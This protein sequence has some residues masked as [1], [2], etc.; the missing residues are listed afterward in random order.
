MTHLP[1]CIISVLV[2]FSSL[3]SRP[4][5][6]H[7]E[8]L[9][10]SHLLSKERHTVANLLRSGFQNKIKNFSK[11][12]NVF[13]RAS[14]STLKGSYCLFSRLLAFAHSKEILLVI[15]ST[16]ERRRGAKIKALGRKR[17]PVASSKGNKVLCIGQEWLVVSILVRIPFIIQTLACPFL[18]ILMP[19][20]RPLRSTRNNK[21]LQPKRHKKMT[22]WTCQVFFLIRK[23]L[24][25]MC[26]CSIVADGAFAC[27]TV[28]HTCK[29]LSIGF[30]SRLRLDARIFDY[31]PLISKKR[32]R[33][34][35]AGR[36][37]NLKEL[38][39]D[40][41]QTW[42]CIEVNWYSGIRKKIEYITGEN[43][44]YN[45]SYEPISIRWVLV[46]DPEN[47]SETIAL[48]STD[49]EH[50]PTWIIESFVSRW[51]L[52]VTFE[53]VRRHLGYET[54]RHWSDKSVDR[55]TPC[56]LASYSLVCLCGIELA[57]TEQIK[58]QV[59]SWYKK[60]YV[61]FSDVLCHVR[62]EILRF[63]FNLGSSLDTTLHK[64]ALDELINWVAAA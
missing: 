36:R 17:D 56:I 10:S 47:K 4:V 29:N 45:F 23:W 24:G 14:W 25:K 62:S 50:S 21:D 1:A 35:K 13:R 22:K 7:I 12:Y 32:G 49:L 30:I 37:I 43:L 44:W 51:K 38:A 18:S 2:H 52:E 53:E 15:D 46:R 6:N 20:E 60:E 28:A 59:C 11:F 42:T 9:F 27:L 58:P 5:F 34:V 8:T 33:P 16:I 40:K 41:M 39:K 63:R 48:F 26:K 55:I 57:K 31:P 3:F 64:K 54:S 19:P 61:T